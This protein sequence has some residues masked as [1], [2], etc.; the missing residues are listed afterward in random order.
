[1]RAVF[2]SLLILAPSPA[3]APVS[4]PRDHGAHPDSALEWWYW[5]GHLSGA[6]GRAYG[7]QVTFFR[8]R[9]VHLAHFAWSDL[10]AGKFAFAEK[11]PLKLGTTVELRIQPFR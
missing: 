1:M 2:L 4:F 3:T 8:L 6:G 10:A 9:D 11:T 5:T 7:F